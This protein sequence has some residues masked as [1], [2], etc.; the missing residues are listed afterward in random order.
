MGFQKKLVTLFALL[1]FYTAYTQTNIKKNVH[2]WEPKPTNLATKWSKDV[3][4]DNAL[5]EYPRPQMTRSSW[6]NLNGLWEYAILDTAAK[7]EKYQGN[8]LVPYP[9]ESGLSGVKKQLFPNQVLWYRRK[10]SIAKIERESRYILHFGAVDYQCTVYVNGKE[11]DRHI[12]GYQA[13]SVDITHALKRG[14]NELVVSVVDPSDKGTNPHGKQVLN[15]KGIVYTSCSG[16]WQTVWLETV[17]EVYIESLKMIPDIDNERLQIQ[18]NV[19]GTENYLVEIVSD[20]NQISGK[21]N[22]LL[23]LPVPD[24]RLWAP[25]DPYLYYL[26]IRLLKNG[27][28]LDSVKSYFGMR[29]IEIKVDSNGNDRIFLNNHYMFNLGVLD[30]GYW[31]DGVYTAPTDEALKYDIEITKAMGFNTIRKHIKLEPARWYYHCDRLGILVWQDMPTPAN[32]GMD[33]KKEFEREIK[34]NIEQLY[35]YPS[36]ICWVLFNEGWNRYDQK[37]I[38]EETKRLDSTRMLDGHS[39]ENYDREAPRDLARRWSASDLTDIHDYPGPNIAPKHPGKARVIGEWGGVRVP[40]PSHQWDNTKSWG[41]VETTHIDFAK[42]YELMIKH[43][44]VYEEEGLSASIFTQTTDVEIEENGLIT[45][46][47]EVI[48]LPIQEIKAIN[49]IMLP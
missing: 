36:I 11:V 18:V 16:I 39:G 40:T 20:N 27:K 5:P 35:N 12:G 47:R 31:P 6:R 7:A 29:K 4:P 15:P 24:P 33:S 19:S 42:K 2:V 48:K 46:D 26:T 14:D 1:L 30:Q 45:Y 49:K 8:I 23:Q 38:T 3:S 28:I 9:V 21:P 43:L 41:Y 34:L 37:R 13:F 22:T 17:P 32:M 44:K 25:Q 10:I